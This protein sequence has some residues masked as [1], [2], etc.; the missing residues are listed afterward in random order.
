[1]RLRVETIVECLAHGTVVC[2]PGV[3]DARLPDGFSVESPPNASPFIP[4][5]RAALELDRPP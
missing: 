1:M 5:D 4:A 3:R 2:G